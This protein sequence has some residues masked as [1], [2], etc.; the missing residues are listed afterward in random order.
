MREIRFVISS[1]ISD[2]YFT[3]RDIYHDP[4]FFLFF[5]IFFLSSL[6]LLLFMKLSNDIYINVNLRSLWR[7]YISECIQF[8][9][10]SR[11]LVLSGISICKGKLNFVFDSYKRGEED[12]GL[13]CWNF[14]YLSIKYSIPRVDRRSLNHEYI[15]VRTFNIFLHLFLQQHGSDI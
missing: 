13:P 11:D 15:R 1:A 3:S 10:N 5:F 9:K 8:M 2:N 14:R 12:E 7:V 4:F 6:F